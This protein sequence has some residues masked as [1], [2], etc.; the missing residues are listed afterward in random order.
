MTPEA[1]ISCTQ[2]IDN[3]ASAIARIFT[4]NRTPVAIRDDLESA[5]ARLSYAMRQVTDAI[6]YTLEASRK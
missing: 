1:N 2:A 4:G 5:R 6:A 3:A